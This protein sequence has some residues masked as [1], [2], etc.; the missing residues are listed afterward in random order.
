[1]ENTYNNLLNF[2]NNSFV[3]NEEDKKELETINPDDYTCMAPNM[4]L[5]E[6][7]ESF[8]GCNNVLDYGAGNGW[9]SIAMVKKG[10]KHVT[11][12][13]VAPNFKNVVEAYSNAF[14]VYDKL[15]I[16]CVD[17]NYLNTVDDNTFDGF[18]VSNVVDV[19]PYDMAIEIIKN[20]SRITKPGSTIIF[21]MN[22]YIDTKSLN[23]PGYVVDGSHIFIDGIL[24]LNSLS[25]NEWMNIFNKYFKDIKLSYFSWPGE[26]EEKRRLFI[27]KK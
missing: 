3:L 15:D 22:Y 13:D 7:L 25:D 2:W 17:Y 21:S 18:F 6:A 16:K 10:A 12:V 19:I 8:N 27:M 20:A 23:V 11:S 5:V 14:K 26:D 9:A 1:M 4:K 24:R